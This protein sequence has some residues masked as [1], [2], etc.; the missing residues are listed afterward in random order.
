[1]LVVIYLPVISIADLTY[2]Q[3]ALRVEIFIANNG[4]I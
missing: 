4:M 2:W 1:M 3:Y